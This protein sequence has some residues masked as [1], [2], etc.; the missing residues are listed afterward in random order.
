[1]MIKAC[2]SIWHQRKRSLL[3]L[4]AVALF[5]AITSAAWLSILDDNGSN[6]GKRDTVLSGWGREALQEVRSGVAALSPIADANACGMGASSCFKCHDGKRALA[7]KMD[8][9][10]DTWHSDHKSVD[11]SCVGCHKGN[12][13]LIKKEFAHEGMIKDARQ[14]PMDTCDTCHKRGAELV[15]RYQK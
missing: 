4:G 2:V 15:I 9:K 14:K 11:G 7:P 1:M 10:S 12:P 6:A 3:M 8:P 5:F 13:R